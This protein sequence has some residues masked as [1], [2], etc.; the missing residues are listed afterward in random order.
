MLLLPLG[1]KQTCKP[2]SV[3]RQS[4]GGDHLS[5]MTVARHLKRP[6]RGQ[7]VPPPNLDLAESKAGRPYV[8]LFGLAPDGVCPADWSPSRW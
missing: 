5:G 1:A 6:T 3:P 8:L 4:R 2:S 7:A